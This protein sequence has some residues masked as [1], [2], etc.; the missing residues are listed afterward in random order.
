[1]EVLTVPYFV[2]PGKGEEN[3]EKETPTEGPPADADTEKVALP[4][5]EGAVRVPPEDNEKKQEEKKFDYELIETSDKPGSIKVF[6]VHVPRTVYDE[7][8][9]KTLKELKKSVVIDGFRK[10][11]A[12]HNLIKRQFRKEI[13]QDVMNELVPNVT[14]QILQKEN[15]TKFLDPILDESKVEEEQ[16]IELTISVEI[17]PKLDIKHEDYTGLTITAGERKITDE[18]VTGELERLQKQ[19]ASIEPKEEGGVVEKE[20]P[21]VAHVEVKDEHGHKIPAHC[22]R[23]RFFTN[24][25]TAFPEPVCK[26]LLGKPR[27]AKVEVAIDEERK[28]PTGETIS[29]KEIWKAEIVEIKKYTLPALDDD[30]AKDMGNFNALA[31]LK[32][33]IFD[34]LTRSEKEHAKEHAFE[35]L[36][37]K[38]S[39]KFPFEPPASLVEYHKHGMIKSDFQLLKQMGIPVSSLRIS[40]EKYMESKQQDAIRGV[41]ESFILKEV[42]VHE[43]LE[44]TEDDLNAELE[45]EAVRVG[46]KSLAI[47]AK[48]EADEQLDSFKD[49]ILTEKVKKFLLENNLITYEEHKESDEGAAHNE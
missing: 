6:K 42:A 44:V 7:L 18:M 41:K 26:E 4:A 22:G 38:I 27:G 31:D 34:D 15:L 29:K 12:P 46:R 19:N 36:I 8:S 32:V 23:D 30:F 37:D 24:L 43:K 20:N 13:N 48:L 5:G 45:K 1:V 39:E 28:K 14:D 3:P 17:I 10:G 35:R 47:R 9:E 40:P 16:P 2:K 25:E 11:K 33:K 21:I 49:S